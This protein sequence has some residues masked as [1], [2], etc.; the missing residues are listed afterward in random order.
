MKFTRILLTVGIFFGAVAI[1]GGLKDVN[2]DVGGRKWGG[3]DN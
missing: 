3:E 1:T 2:E